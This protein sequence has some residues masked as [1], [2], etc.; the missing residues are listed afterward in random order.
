[1]RRRFLR[2]AQAAASLSHPN[3]VSVYETGE[4][5]PVCYIATEYC[6]GKTL[7]AWL[8]DKRE[9]VLLLAAATLV[10]TLAAALDYAH[11]RGSSTAI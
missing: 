9:P 4:W 7:A 5:G 2:E 6:P 10:A 8:R 11:N 3:L 1:M